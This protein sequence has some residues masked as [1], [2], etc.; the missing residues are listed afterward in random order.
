MTEEFKT[1]QEEFWAGEFGNEYIKRNQGKYFLA[2]NLEFFSKALAKAAKME[3]CIEFGA[4]IGNNLQALKLLYPDHQQFAIEIN[5]SAVKELLKFIPEKNVFQTSILYFEP[6]SVE[7][8]CDV[9]IIKGVLIHINPEFLSAVYKKLYSVAR[10]YILV[11]EYYN[12][13]P[14]TVNYRGHTER[15]FKRDF[16]GEMMD[17]FPDLELLDYGFSYH[18]DRNFPQDDITWFLMEKR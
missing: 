12:T 13:T 3:S 4:N 9:V 7:G 6:S 1:P 10:R 8:G 16:A 5:A 18:R 17:L 11:C 2:A 15:L 14:I